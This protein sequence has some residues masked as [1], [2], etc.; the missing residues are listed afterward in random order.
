MIGNVDTDPQIESFQLYSD[1]AKNHRWFEKVK[2]KLFY[3]KQNST[4]LA[5]DLY[6]VC[7]VIF[8]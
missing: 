8:C 6:F 4:Y 5:Y 7:D 1:L 3:L 2:K